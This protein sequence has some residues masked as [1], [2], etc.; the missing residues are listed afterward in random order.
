MIDWSDVKVMHPESIVIGDSFSAGRGLW[1]E[2]VAGKGKLRIGERVNLSD[3]VHVGCASSVT[4][5][6]GV[7]IGSKVLI[8]DHS[9][10]ETGANG[11]R[12]MQTPPNLRPIVSKGPVTIADNV[13]IGDGACIL[14]NVTIGTGAIIGANA[15]VIRDVPA[16][17]IWAGVPAKQVWPS[18]AEI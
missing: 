18:S 5:G 1:L 10:G 15:V 2:S 16:Q 14:P 7:L 11:A 6:N 8:T 12:D 17:S 4:I 3:Y 9:H 13:W